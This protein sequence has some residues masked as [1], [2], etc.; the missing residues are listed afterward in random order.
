MNDKFLCGMVLGFMVGALVMHKSPNAQE[1]LEMGK[2][3]V[4]KA[5][6]KI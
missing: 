1:M 3:E 4:K 2:Q 6:D 5:I